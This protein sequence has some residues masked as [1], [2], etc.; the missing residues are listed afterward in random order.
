M[1]LLGRKLPSIL[2]A[3][4][5]AA[6]FTA[7]GVVNA[8]AAFPDTTCASGTVAAGTYHSLTITGFCKVDG[9][10]VMVQRNVTIAPGG[11]L[12][13]AF[14]GSDLTIG[15]DMLIQTG[16]KLG[17]GCEPVEFPCF[18]N[19]AGHTNHS[20][21]R[22]L[23]A[24]NATLVVVH[25]SH[26]VGEVAETG[27]GGGLTCA[28]LFTNGPPPFTDYTDNM[29]G[30][31]VTV[32]RLHTCWDGFL[33]NKVGGTVNW[34]D[35]HTVMADGNLMSTNTIHHNLNCFENSPKPHLS[36]FTPVKNTV[37]GTARG[38]CTALSVPPAL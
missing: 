20:I 2:S 24:E 30:G 22:N 17:L 10:N 11:A 4:A 1:H 15:R 35:N 25:R 21:G 13:A 7:S 5:V 16:G 33:R 28:P 31:D 26:I 9:G 29:I 12:L 27:G 38:Q 6:L 8:A 36:D 14:S 32:A 34:N 3:G 19:S 37:F 23:V 18:N